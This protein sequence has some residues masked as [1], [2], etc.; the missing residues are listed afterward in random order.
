[1]SP[2]R[3]GPKK[4]RRLASASAPWHTSQSP[5][6]PRPDLG[7]PQQHPMAK[8]HGHLPLWLQSNKPMLA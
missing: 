1:M 2:W 3:A 6:Q 8:S 7:R 4:C 5:Q